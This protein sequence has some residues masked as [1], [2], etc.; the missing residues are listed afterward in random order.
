M[1]DED[2]L[3]SIVQNVTEIAARVENLRQNLTSAEDQLTEWEH[4]T[5]YSTP[6]EYKTGHHIP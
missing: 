3:D 2:L 5:G 4:A 6:E 1:N